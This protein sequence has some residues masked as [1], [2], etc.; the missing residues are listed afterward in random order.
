VLADPPHL[1]PHQRTPS[2][3]PLSSSCSSYRNS[4]LK[5]SNPCNHRNQQYSIVGLTNAA[6]TLVERYSYSAYGTLGIYDANG[7][8]RTTST[9]ANRYT[10]TGRE[11]DPDLNLYH[12]RARWYD[13]A[14]GGFISRDPLGYVDG[15]SLYRGYFGVNKLDPLG[16]LVSGGVEFQKLKECNAKCL[17]DHPGIMVSDALF[18][19]Y[20]KCDTL[21]HPCA[22]LRNDVFK[23]IWQGC[24]ALYPD[25]NSDDFISCIGEAKC[26]ASTLEQTCRNGARPFRLV[27]PNILGGQ[28][29]RGNW[30]YEWAYGYEDAINNLDPKYI[31][32]KTEFACPKLEG[33]ALDA[34]PADGDYP[35]HYWLKISIAN[36]H[37][38]VDDGFME[39]FPGYAHSTRPC[40]GDIYHFPAWRPG[41]HRH[42]CSPV[43]PSPPKKEFFEE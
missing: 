43:T 4:K 25:K 12:F 7:T 10:Y 13:P 21:F 20:R 26:A 6:G 31:T 9:Y 32:C 15:M 19:C 11:Y 22:I 30:C 42:E 1:F 34:Y 41:K 8:V 3:P 17:E 27:R 37:I 38:F 5:T 40:G 24:F 28:T 36:T 33:P 18:E 14:T 2:P 23:F 16:L 39:G 29:C 35:V